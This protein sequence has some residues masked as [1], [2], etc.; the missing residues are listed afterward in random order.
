MKWYK[1][2]LATG[3]C[4][5]TLT[6]YSQKKKKDKKDKTKVE[7]TTTTKTMKLENELDSVSYSIGVSIAQN[8][9]SQG[10]DELNYDVLAK[11]IEDVMKSNDLA[12]TPEQCQSTVQEYMRSAFDRKTAA[13][14]QKGIDFLAENK[15]KKGIVVTESG[16][17][18]EVLVQGTGD[19]K[20][21]IEDN[22]TAHY[23]G[24]LIDGTVFDS[25]VD[26]GQ[27]FQTKVGGVIKAWIEALQM[28]TVGTKL[29]IYCPSDLAYGA[30]GAGG[31][32][33]PHEVLIFEMELIS[34]DN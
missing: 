14:K 2:M 15:S 32:I 26:R 18:Y 31:K 28:M 16:L 11:A 9:Q 6:T 4:F 17:Q 12:M 20:P 25:S 29:R 22:V 19:R 10:I 5:A 21:G 13:N 3:L 33:G 27:P 1:L 30:R 23:H 8:M 24:T 7:T 34:I